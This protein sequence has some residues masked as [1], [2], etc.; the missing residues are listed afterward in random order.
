[1]KVDRPAGQPAPAVRRIA[2]DPRRA[3]LL[4]S[5]SMQKHPIIFLIRYPLDLLFLS[6]F[7]D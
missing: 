1:V 5:M 4:A 6:V 7:P 2:V 3:A